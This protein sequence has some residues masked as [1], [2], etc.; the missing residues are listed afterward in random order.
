MTATDTCDGPLVWY[1][2]TAGGAV[3]ECAGC[4]YLIVAGNVNDASHAHTPI[5][6]EGLAA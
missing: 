4:D 1:E 6:R 3:L 2:V 5:L